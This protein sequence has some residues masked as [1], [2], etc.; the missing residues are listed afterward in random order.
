MTVLSTSKSY[1]DV[2]PLLFHDTLIWL[3]P[4]AVAVRP[5]GVDGGP[6]GRKA[7]IQ[8]AQCCALDGLVVQ[9]RVPVEPAV[10]FAS[11]ASV[12]RRPV[13]VEVAIAVMLAGGAM[14][15][16]LLACIVTPLMST[17]LLVAV[18]IVG[19]VTEVAATVVATVDGVTSIGDPVSTPENRCIIP[20][21]RLDP[22]PVHVYDADSDPVTTR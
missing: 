17:A 2:V 15:V 13:P 19:T 16:L 5:L 18:V 21:D 6:K 7:V 20:V 14:A 22:H 4:A 9:T 8:P 11:Y 12:D 10:G 1:S 3:T